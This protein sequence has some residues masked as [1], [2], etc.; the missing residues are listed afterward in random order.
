VK[1][2]DRPIIVPLTHD[3]LVE[4]LGE[5]GRRP[6]V[7]GI[8]AYVGGKLVGVGGLFF[9]P[10]HVVAFCELREE[11]RPYRTTI[12]MAAAVLIREAKR[13]HKRIIAMIDRTEPTAEK[14]LTKLGF[15]HQQGDLWTWL[16]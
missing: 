3:H 14:W 7:K 16:A 2:S 15:T 1:R 11:A 9:M 13:R 4:M 8:A 10:G 5:D 12:A 6:S